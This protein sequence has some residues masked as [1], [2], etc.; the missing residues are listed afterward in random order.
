MTL[1]IEYQNASLEFEHFMV[2]ARDLAGLN[3]TNMAWNMVVG[4]LHTFRRRLN[5]REGLRFAGVLPP[6][7]RAI[8]VEDWNIDGP[9]ASFGTREEL[10]A[11]VRSIRSAHNFSPTNAIAAVAEAL[12]KHVDIAA[13]ER[14]LP[15]LPNG[16]KEFWSC[17]LESS[18]HENGS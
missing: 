11:E 8:F 5:V 6:V 16:S 10:L 17:A 13:F 2:D 15:I 18:K 9:V 7:L 4:V 14:I 12:R 3:T 1:P